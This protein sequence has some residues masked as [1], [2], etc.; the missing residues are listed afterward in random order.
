MNSHT[1]PFLCNAASGS[2][3]NNE[4]LLAPSATWKPASQPHN[5]RE[6][7]VGIYSVPILSGGLVFTA[8][9]SSPTSSCRQSF[10]PFVEK[11]NCILPT[12]SIILTKITSPPLLLH[13]CIAGSEMNLS[14]RQPNLL[15][16]SS[17]S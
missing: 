11:N 4:M 1:L 14:H 9:L 7:C 3:T 2:Q 12:I 5:H 6:A 17:Y 16:L 8:V 13:I 15:V 10:D